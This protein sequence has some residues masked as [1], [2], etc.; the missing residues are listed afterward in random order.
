MQGLIKYKK[1]LKRVDL[2]ILE[3]LIA[4]LYQHGMEK[5]S[6]IA[7]N[8][9]MSYDNCVLYLEVLEIMDFVK[10][11]IGEEGH[12]LLGLTTAGI[13]FYKRL[14]QTAESDSLIKDNLLS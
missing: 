10:Q 1:Q 13:S 14:N 8:S 2:D 11:E 5:K 6:I 12:E 7:R 9:K 3:R 4:V